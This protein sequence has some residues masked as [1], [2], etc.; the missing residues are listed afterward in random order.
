MYQVVI[1]KASRKEVSVLIEHRVEIEHSVSYPQDTPTHAYTYRHMN[2]ILNSFYSVDE[3]FF[4]FLL[5][6]IP[7]L[8]YL[9]WTLKNLMQTIIAN[10]K[11]GEYK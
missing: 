4:I 10:M 9:G 1:E 2:N 6:I 3:S 11:G 8:L 5:A 7:I